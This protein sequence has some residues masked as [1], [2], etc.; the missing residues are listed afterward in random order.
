MIKKIKIEEREDN[1]VAII[2]IFGRYALLGFVIALSIPF[3]LIMTPFILLAFLVTNWLKEY[4]KH[5]Q[6]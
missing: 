1:F 6:H 2:S 4:G 5:K 3:A